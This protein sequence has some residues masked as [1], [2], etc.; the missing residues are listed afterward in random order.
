MLFSRMVIK[1]RKKSIEL[2]GTFF[3]PF[4]DTQNVC[5]VAK[6]GT[7]LSPTTDWLIDVLYFPVFACALPL[8]YCYFCVCVCV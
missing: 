2:G 7:L 6:G 1:R 5:A 8:V 3:E 4:Q